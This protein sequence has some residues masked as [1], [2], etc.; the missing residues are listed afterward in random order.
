MLS[1]WFG[2]LLPHAAGAMTRSRIISAVLLAATVL[3]W[4]GMATGAQLKATGAVGSLG[5][6]M[7]VH[8]TCKALQKGNQ[9]VKGCALRGDGLWQVALDEEGPHC[10]ATATF[11]DSEQTT[12]NFGCVVRRAQSGGQSP[13]VL[14]CQHPASATPTP[15][16][17]PLKSAVSPHTAAASCAL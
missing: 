9:A 11:I 15:R 4:S 14:G 12:S 16:P 10:A 6:S 1:F 3:L 13:R 7:A 5:D 17:L 8:R 2:S